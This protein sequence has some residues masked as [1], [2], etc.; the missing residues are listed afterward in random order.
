MKEKIQV[1]R[2][3][4]A[5]EW[6][7][8]QKVKSATP[9][10]CQDNPTAF[11]KV[12]GSI[13]DAWPEEILAAYNRELETAKQEGRNLLTEKYARMDNLIP[14]VNTNPVISKIVEIELNWQEE[15]MRLY[16][17]LYQRTCRN[18]DDT[19]NGS[20]FAV[21]LHCELETYG[22][23][24]LELY[25]KWVQEA[26]QNNKNFSLDMLEKLAKESGFEG[27]EHAEQHLNRHNYNA[28]TL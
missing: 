17:N 12:R 16:P 3:I 10:S 4:L 20:N 8:F 14:P 25:Y 24:T 21:Y 22:D 2:D 26:V 13:F 15:L 28:D 7:M 5:K 6:E 1:I 18:T 9:A 19:E 11:Q 23:I 27:L